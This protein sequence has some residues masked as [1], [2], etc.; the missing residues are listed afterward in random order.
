MQARAAAL[1]QVQGWASC[2]P[3]CRLASALVLQSGIGR[4]LAARLLRLVLLQVVRARSRVEGGVLYELELKLT[5]QQGRDQVVKVRPAACAA[6]GVLEVPAHV[7]QGSCCGLQCA[8]SPVLRR[9]CR[10]LCTA[11]HAACDA[12]GGCHARHREP[13]YAAVAADP[14]MRRRA[15][16]RGACHF[17]FGPVGRCSRHMAAGGRVNFLFEPAPDALRT[18]MQ[19]FLTRAWA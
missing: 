11:R 16:A 3:P 1:Q 10:H 8:T 6:A 14:G 19:L 17:N 18:A 13:V 12:A 9:S 2:R 5:Q 7:W 4:L 15:A